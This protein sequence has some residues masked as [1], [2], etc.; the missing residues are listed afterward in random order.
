M[1][2]YF[3]TIGLLLILCW[4]LHL[5]SIPSKIGEVVGSSVQKATEA[6]ISKDKRIVAFL[7]FFLLAFVAAFRYWVGTDFRSYYR[8]SGWAEKF[9][10]GDYSDPGF[11][12]FA[13]FSSFLFQGK[14]GALTIC[15]AIITAALFVFTIIKRS[16]NITISLLLFIFV[17]CFTGMF[18]GVRQYLATAILF[19]GFHFVQEKKLL[20]WAVVVAIAT[21][22]HVTAIL[23]FFVYFACNVKC[24]WITITAYFIFAIIMLYLYEPLFNLVGALKQEEIDTDIEA[25]T[26]QVNILRVLV[27]C[28]PFM[29]FFFVGQD[30]IN[31]D[32]DCRVLFNVCLLNA[33]LA[34]ASVNSVYFARFYI[35]TMCFQTLMYPTVLSK[36]SKNDRS[37]FIALLLFFYG[38]FWLYETTKSSSLN[39]FQWIFKYL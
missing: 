21:T 2:V 14:N 3:I 10:H 9:S 27:Q 16:E 15:A 19:A 34:I 13:M 5:V 20:K 1:T 12:L 4:L 37:I 29:M 17:G 31:E 35:Y 38:I 18:N 8:T 36:V 28:V 7:R 26:R 22:I 24:N 32:V 25:I 23:M 30:K 39:N 11:T 33:A 6:R